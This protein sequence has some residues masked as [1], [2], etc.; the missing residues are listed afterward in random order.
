MRRR[1]SMYRL[2]AALVLAMPILAW[3]TAETVESS[4]PVPEYSVRPDPRDCAFP[5]CGGYFLYEINGATPASDKDLCT[6]DFPFAGYVAR[7]MCHLDDG[8]LA[9]IYLSCDKPVIGNIQPDPDYKKFYML[10]TPSCE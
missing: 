2:F 1:H 5:Q 10:V 7:T 8:S 4:L 9:E 3:A 6:A